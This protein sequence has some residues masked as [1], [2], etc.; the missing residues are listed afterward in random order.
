MVGGGEQAAV[1]QEG[2]TKLGREPRRAP[3][4]PGAGA[5]ARGCCPRVPGTGLGGEIRA[6]GKAFLPPPP[7]PR[8]P[9]RGC[10]GPSQGDP[11]GGRRWAPPPSSSY[12][13][14]GLFLWAAH[15]PSVHCEP[16]PSPA[17]PR[18]GRSP[19]HPPPP[20][21]ATSRPCPSAALGLGAGP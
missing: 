5:S 3:P 14:S 17:S 6:G 11:A 9:A 1:G 16:T 21:Q 15:P 18:V 13:F 12:R 19:T 10:G 2:G 4:Q 7:V 20:P 8:P